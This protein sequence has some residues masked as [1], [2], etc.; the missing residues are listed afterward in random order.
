MIGD[1]HWSNAASVNGHIL[2]HS[3]TSGLELD[4]YDLGL[5]GGAGGTLTGVMA[6]TRDAEG[7]LPGGSPGL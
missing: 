5:L 3:R 7:V 6:L 2:V 1:N 4:R